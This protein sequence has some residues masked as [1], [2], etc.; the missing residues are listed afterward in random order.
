MK[1]FLL[2]ILLC[3][4]AAQADTLH[5]LGFSYDF[6]S[7]TSKEQ[8]SYAFHSPALTWTM[9]G[10]EPA[11]WTAMASL[12]IPVQGRQDGEVVATSRY[13]RRFW[14]ADGLLGR[15]Y[16]IN[17]GEGFDVEG[18][19]GVH[20]NYVSLIG[21]EGYRDWNSFSGGLGVITTARWQLGQQFLGRPL[22]LGGFLNLSSDFFDLLHGGDLSWALN[23]SAGAQ[24]ALA[25]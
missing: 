5:G 13:Y 15:A 21:K 20:L 22:S 17:L 9:S 10:A 4:G 18:G 2:A 1:K 14:G 23:F 3:A 7:V 11:G 6:T 8:S 12:L 19:L 24:L 16:R 25:F